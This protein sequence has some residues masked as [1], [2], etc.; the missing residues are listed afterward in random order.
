MNKRLI[1]SVIIMELENTWI[2]DFGKFK[3]VLDENDSDVSNQ[4]R[5]YGLYEDEKLEIQTFEKY[6]K[7]GM[8]VLDLGANVGFYTMLSRSLVRENGRVFAFEPSS[9]NAN[10]I[11]ASIEENSFTNVKVIEAAVSDEIGVSKL[12]LSPNLNSGHSLLNLDFKYDKNWEGEKTADV[13]VITIDDYLEKKVGDFK[14]DFIK[15]DIEG[16]EFRAIKG[17]K[18]VFDANEHLILISEFWPNGFLKNNKNP[19]DYLEML[20]G[21]NFTINHIDE[22]QGKVYPVSA[23]QLIEIANSRKEIAEQDKDTRFWGYYTNIICIR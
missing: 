11:R 10:L 4:I 22:L 21:L 1:H 5:E 19:K 17:M 3:M 14:V 15:M 12:H 20:A 8:T 9:R 23:K 6:I 16:S 2:H 13:K 7:K 18:R